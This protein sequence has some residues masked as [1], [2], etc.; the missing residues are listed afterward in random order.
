MDVLKNAERVKDCVCLIICDSICFNI[1][2]ILSSL[3]KPL[4]QQISQA[5]WS[6]LACIAL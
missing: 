5:K 4:V 6:L 1:E 3:L 2:H